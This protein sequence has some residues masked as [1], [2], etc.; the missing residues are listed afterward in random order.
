MTQSYKKQPINMHQQ[1]LDDFYMVHILAITLALRLSMNCLTINWM[2][3]VY[4]H[5]HLIEK[6]C[7]TFTLSNNHTV[8]IKAPLTLSWRKSISYRNQ[9]ID[10]LCKSMDWILYD[11]SLRH[12]RVKPRL[13]QF[14]DE[15]SRFKL[16]A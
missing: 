3:S 6:I 12:E 15:I 5:R 10:L 4:K 9:S 13:Q 16:K 7:F 14:M 11:N 2:N 8:N 1:S